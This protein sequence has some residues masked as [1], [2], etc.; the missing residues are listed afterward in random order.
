MA[1][2]LLNGADL[3]RY[4]PVTSFQNGA[5]NGRKWQESLL[6]VVNQIMPAKYSAN[7]LEAVLHHHTGS[8]DMIVMDLLHGINPYAWLAVHAECHS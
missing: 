4:L 3:S 7:V 2:D 8:P 1:D 6:E 5:L